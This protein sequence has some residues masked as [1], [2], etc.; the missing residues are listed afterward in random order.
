VSGLRISVVSPWFKPCDSDLP[1]TIQRIQKE[2]PAWIPK[3]GNTKKATALMQ[4]LDEHLKVKEFDEA[5]K[6]ADSILKMM[7]VSS[8]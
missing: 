1:L 3:T 5:E 2:L 8:G 6:T 7:G 4:R